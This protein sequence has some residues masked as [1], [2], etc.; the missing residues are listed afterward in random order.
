MFVGIDVAHDP[1]KKN[2]SVVG[3]VASLNNVCTKYVSICRM[4]AVHQ[5][6]VDNI[7]TAFIDALATY[8]ETNNYYPDRIIVFRDGGCG[9]D[10]T[11][12]C[13]KEVDQMMKAIEETCP[14]AKFTFV[15]VQKRIGQRFFKTDQVIMMSC[16]H[17]GITF[18]LHCS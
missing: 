6:L 4:Q 8:F 3:L 18:T 17:K 12:F 14:H 9:S 16:I 1:L 7:R 11:R 10:P 2:P 5:E 13:Q 15:V